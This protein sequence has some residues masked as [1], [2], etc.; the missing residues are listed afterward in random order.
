[1]GWT[2]DILPRINTTNDD[3]RTSSSRRWNK[4]GCCGCGPKNQ[5]LVK[6]IA[7]ELKT[8]MRAFGNEGLR[9]FQ[10]KIN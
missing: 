7:Q 1:M 9:T 8:R 5:E 3:G 6:E 2:A 4:P 10:K